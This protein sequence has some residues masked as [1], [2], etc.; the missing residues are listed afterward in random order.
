MKTKKFTVVE[1]S[2]RQMMFS[3]VKEF[4]IR[5]TKNMSFNEILRW[6]RIIDGEFQKILDSRVD[7][8]REM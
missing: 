2:E 1:Y 5:R 7:T 6:K 3:D 4:I 8:G